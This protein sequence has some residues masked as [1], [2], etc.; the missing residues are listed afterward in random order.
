MITIKE[1][2]TKR[3]LNKF[4]DFPVKLY[5]DNPYYVPTLAV[6]EKK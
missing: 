1:V 2:K 4:I 6:D 3:D 5:K